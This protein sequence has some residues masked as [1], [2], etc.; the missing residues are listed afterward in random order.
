MP[1]LEFLK[2]LS[3][4]ETEFKNQL[5]YRNCWPIRSRKKTTIPHTIHNQMKETECFHNFFQG[6][7]YQK[8]VSKWLEWDKVIW[9]A[10]A[11]YKFLPNKHSKESPFFLLF[12][13]D[14]LLN[15]KLD[16]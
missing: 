4:M 15:P 7:V 16:I 3:G 9:L 8:G 10:C 14:S 6:F 13:R 11:T 2:I 1:N 5:F 12:G